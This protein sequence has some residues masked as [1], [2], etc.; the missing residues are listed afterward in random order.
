VTIGVI[1]GN[2]MHFEVVRQ[3]NSDQRPAPKGGCSSTG[4]GTDSLASF[5]LTLAAPVASAGIDVIAY[6]LR[7]HGRSELPP[8]GYRV[9][10]FVADLTGLLDELAV[11]EPV[12]PGRQQLRRHRRFQL[13]GGL[14]G[15]GGQHRLDRGGAATQHWGGQDDRDAGQHHAE[16]QTEEFFRW[17]EA[18][19]GRHHTRLTRSAAKKLLSTTMASE[20][21]LGPL[22]D[23]KACR[24]SA[25]RC[26]PLWAVRASRRTTSPRWAPLCRT[27]GRRC[28]RGRTTPCWC[29]PTGFVRDLLLTWIRQHDPVLA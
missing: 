22:M 17:L 9:A 3:K 11:T 20:V 29:S 14:S 16:I 19:F 13:C 1:N 23:S 18:T 24:K 2:R 28:W 25:V 21:P 10:D 7:G 26:C 12:P 5:Y 15:A 6:D 8:T 27:A 4:L